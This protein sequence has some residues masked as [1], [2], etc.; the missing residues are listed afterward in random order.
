MSLQTLTPEFS[1]FCTGPGQGLQTHPSGRTMHCVWAMVT[2]G[3]FPGMGAR[4]SPSN[5]RTGHIP[6]W[7][8]L[9]W[10]WVWSCQSLGHFHCDN[11]PEYRRFINPLM[12]R[13]EVSATTLLNS[14]RLL[15]KRAACSHLAG[16]R[17]PPGN[18]LGSIQQGW[19]F[20]CHLLSEDLEALKRIFSSL[21]LPTQA[22]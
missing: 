22:H 3:H 8:F 7:A 20:P 19:T 6:L 18:E 12:P 16:C 13:A 1:G 17:Q 2:S 14:W 15:S 11:P 9:L 5:K 10:T 4:C 21:P